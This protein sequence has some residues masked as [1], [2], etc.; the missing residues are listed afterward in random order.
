MECHFQELKKVKFIKEL[1]VDSHRI[2]VKEDKL[3][4]AVLLLIE[5]GIVCY[6]HFLEELWVMIAFSSLN[7]LLLILLWMEVNAEV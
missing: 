4:G 6:T 1:L 2:L 7:I 3:I 5:L